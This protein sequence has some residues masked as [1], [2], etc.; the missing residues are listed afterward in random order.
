[1]PRLNFT[2]ICV[3][4][5]LLAVMWCGFMLL[6]IANQIEDKTIRVTTATAVPI[7]E[8][9]AALHAD[10]T[11]KQS[12]IDRIHL[13]R[14]NEDSLTAPCAQGRDPS[15][16]EMEYYNACLLEHDLGWLIFLHTA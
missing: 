11:F 3:S 1:M 5:I 10:R 7:E 14:C 2:S 8:E 15:I 16:C 13:V 12:E 4:L 9:C 6:A